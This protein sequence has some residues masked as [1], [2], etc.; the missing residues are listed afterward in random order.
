MKDAIYSTATSR[1]FGEARRRVEEKAHLDGFR[2]LQV[3]DLQKTLKEKGFSVEPTVIVEVCNAALASEFLGL[4]PSA[5]LLMPCKVVVEER[6]GNVT[7]STLLPESMVEGDRLKTIARQ[8]GVKLM[9][10]VD[11]AASSPSCCR[12]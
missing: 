5:A 11:T 3:H 2:V 6:A 7:L 12:I 9:S 10:L 4:D 1:T 8:L